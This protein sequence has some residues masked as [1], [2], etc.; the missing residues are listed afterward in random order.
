MKCDSNYR[1]YRIRYF[2]V[3]FYL[4]A[5]MEVDD[6]KI[7]V[8]GER[9]NAGASKRMRDIHWWCIGQNI[10]YKTKFQYR[11]E[12]PIRA[13]I[14]NFYSYCRFMIESKMTLFGTKRAL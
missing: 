11:K 5:R 13:N 3:V 1:V 9:I 6:Y 12:Y 14:W 7:N 8:L 4:F 10:K 2:N